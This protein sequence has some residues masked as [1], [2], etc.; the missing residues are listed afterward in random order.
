[1]LILY[2]WVTADKGAKTQGGLYV[3][4]GIRLC[5]NDGDIKVS[6]HKEKSVSHGFQ[7]CKKQEES[8]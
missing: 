3:P 7:M 1:M 5:Y 2:Y 4:F 6:Y 8:L